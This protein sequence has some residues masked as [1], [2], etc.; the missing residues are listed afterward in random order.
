M[1]NVSDKSFREYQNAYFMFSNFFFENYAIYGIMQKNIVELGRPQAYGQNMQYLSFF[2][3]NNCG[4]KVPQCYVTHTLPA[5]F[6]DTNRR[7][8][9]QYMNVK[10]I[11]VHKIAKNMSGMYTQHISL[12]YTFPL[13]HSNTCKLLMCTHQLCCHIFTVCLQSLSGN[14]FPSNCSLDGNL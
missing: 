13:F 14:N 7:Y 9:F 12:K 6:S 3:C 2:H 5:L 1:R 10:T 11:E 4:M 8:V